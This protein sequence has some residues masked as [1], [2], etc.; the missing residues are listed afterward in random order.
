MAFTFTFFSSLP[1]SSFSLS[2]K[3][4]IFFLI[5]IIFFAGHLLQPTS[6]ECCY[7]TTLHC[8]ST[9]SDQNANVSFTVPYICQNFSEPTWG[10]FRNN[11]GVGSCNMFACACQGGCRKLNETLPGLNCTAV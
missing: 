9:T 8:R 6:G 2:L 3:H 4:S 11:C 10:F 5:A 1:F 7:P